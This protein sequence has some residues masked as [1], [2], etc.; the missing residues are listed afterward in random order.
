MDPLLAA[1]FLQPLPGPVHRRRR[2]PPSPSPCSHATAKGCASKSKRS[3]D[4][5]AHTD[6]QRRPSAWS[7]S[8]A[9]RK[10]RRSTSKTCERRKQA[11]GFT[12]PEIQAHNSNERQTLLPHTPLLR[13]FS[14]RHL[15]FQYSAH[16]RCLISFRGKQTT[17]PVS[18]VICAVPFE[19]RFRSAVEAGANFIADIKVYR[20]YRMASTV[21]REA[22]KN[23][24]LQESRPYFQKVILH[25]R[26]P[27]VSTSTNG[28]QVGMERARVV[29]RRVEL[30]SRV[31]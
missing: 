26:V 30:A 25:S 3:S 28:E 13:S 5:T 12:H 15:L 14:T 31:D 17:S 23:A 16:A 4:P 6:R 9:S 2:H 7:I 27:S 29:Y 8:R 19:T 10:R 11:A 1:G 21:V 22:R 20:N 18:L 24:Y